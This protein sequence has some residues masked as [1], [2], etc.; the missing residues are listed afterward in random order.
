VTNLGSLDYFLGWGLVLSNG[1]SSEK[2]MLNE[3]FRVCIMLSLVLYPK[4]AYFVSLTLTAEYFGS[5]RCMPVNKAITI[6]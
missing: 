6:T 5:Q 4:R 1:Y 2:L 3:G